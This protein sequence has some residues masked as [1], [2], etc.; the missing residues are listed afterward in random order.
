MIDQILT[1]LNVLTLVIDFE[2]NTIIWSN[3]LFKQMPELA[4]KTMMEYI[5]M[6]FRNVY[7]DQMIFKIEKNVKILGSQKSE[8][9][10]Y[11]T[12]LKIKSS[13]QTWNWVLSKSYI[14]EQKNGKPSKIAVISIP[15]QLTSGL[16]RLADS[17]SGR[18]LKKEPKFLTPKE[19][20]VLKD[21]VD[22]MTSKEVA[23]KY[24]I[25]IHTV[26]T[27]R[28]RILKKLAVKNTPELIRFALKNKLA[29]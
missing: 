1:N 21:I 15:I 12:L 27:H 13:K 10:T 2:E 11:T 17:R 26:Q 28:K 7:S 24:F 20:L 3:K 22:G 23:E 6:V 5:P 16:K 4:I 25:S 29:I 9:N 18:I 14:T 8:D 19:Q